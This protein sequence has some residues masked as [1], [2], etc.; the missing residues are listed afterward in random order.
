MVENEKKKETLDFNLFP[1]VNFVLP[2]LRP[3][4]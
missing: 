3:Q 4:L 2:Y 1:D